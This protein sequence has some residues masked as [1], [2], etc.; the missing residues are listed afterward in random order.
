VA[1]GM[2]RCACI[3]WLTALAML[4]ASH[5]QAGVTLGTMQQPLATA[6]GKTLLDEVP[7]SS[8]LKDGQ[9]RASGRS[10]ALP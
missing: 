10:T 8:E 6:P 7:D 9:T 2:H 1:H 3:L 5:L 4:P